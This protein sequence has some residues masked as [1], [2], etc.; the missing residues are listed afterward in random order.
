MSIF[1]PET[2]MSSEISGAMDTTVAPIPEGTYP[3]IVEDIK[4]REVTGKDGSP[5]Y[6]CEIT[7]DI[8]DDN[9]KSNLG[10]DKI[11]VR[12]T[13]WLDLLASGQLDNGKGKNIGVGKIRAAVNQNDPNT[14]WNLN[15][16]KGA[17]PALV[18]VKHSPDR[19][20]PSIVYGNVTKVG[21]LN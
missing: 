17:G 18:E 1:D 6:P 7:W 5:R 13:V 14:R 9:L 21:R 12:Q 10:R 19:N 4:I 15:M 20:D 16:L 2:F 8:V 11:T 3:A